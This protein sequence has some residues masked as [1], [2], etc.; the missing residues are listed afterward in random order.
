MM[1]YNLCLYASGLLE[2]LFYAEKKDFVSHESICFQPDNIV[3]FLDALLTWDL[4]YL[5][6]II[7][8]QTA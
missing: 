7:A 2:V 6:I 1:T 5:S 8:I 4:I 3:P